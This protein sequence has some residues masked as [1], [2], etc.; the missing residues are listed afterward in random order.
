MAK[1]REIFKVDEDALKDM[2]A[3]ES[4]AC[5]KYGIDV[6]ENVLPAT[7]NE[8]NVSEVETQGRGKSRKTIR[9]DPG[10]EK[11]V[12]M[13]RELFLDKRKSVHRKQT[14]ISYDMYCKLS[15]ILPLL[16]DDMS[17]PAFLDNV[18]AHHLETYSKELG[19]LF[20]RKTQEPF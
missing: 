8:I 2:M 20:R 12:E 1:K 16:S 7:E 13:Y 18:L 17:V 14:Y 9:A 19:E 11:R 10:L 5:G 15:R 4:I 6:S 3:S